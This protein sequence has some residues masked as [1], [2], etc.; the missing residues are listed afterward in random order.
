MFENIF[1]CV[2]MAASGGEIEAVLQ[3][4]KAYNNHLYRTFPRE[5]QIG[6]DDLASLASAYNST[7][8]Q[9]GGGLVL[10][11][12]SSANIVRSNTGFEIFQRSLRYTSTRGIGFFLSADHN[13]QYWLRAAGPTGFGGRWGVVCFD[14]QMKRLDG[15]GSQMLSQ[16]NWTSSYGGC[17]RNGSDGSFFSFRIYD[18]SIAFI[19]VFFAGGTNPAV[20]NGLKVALSG[21]A[22]S[23]VSLYRPV[24]LGSEGRKATANPNSGIVG[25]YQAGDFIANAAPASGQ[26]TGWGANVGGWLAPTW[27]A[28]TAYLAGHL[29]LND[30]DKI[31]EC[32]TAGTS[33]GSG[34][35]TGTGSGIT[36]G[37]AVWNYLGPKA[38]F[39]AGP[40]Y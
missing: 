13:L 29:R 26:P 19:L 35:P 10:V 34:G 5:T 6:F 3:E 20:V 37:T 4:G 33:A 24:F 18:P 7:Q 8:M 9:I 22:A 25:R 12:S 32:V 11:D 31:Y 15:S 2:Y 36:D 27:A 1:N 40:N 23:L 17:Y 14:A 16:G 21:G 28:D 39:I 38:T 30:T